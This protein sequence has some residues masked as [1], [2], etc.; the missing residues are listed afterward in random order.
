M[1]ARRPATIPL[2][3]RYPGRLDVQCRRDRRRQHKR[4]ICC[5][6]WRHRHI[7]YS[8]RRRHR[9]HAHHRHLQPR[10]RFPGSHQVHRRP[11]GG[12]QAE[13]KITVSCDG[14]CTPSTSWSRRERAARASRLITTS[15]PFDMH[16]RRDRRRLDQH[17]F[18]HDRGGQPVGPDRGR[19]AGQGRHRPTRTI[20]SPGP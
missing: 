3:R 11:G 17:C 18:G 5:H 15:Q 16:R 8:A 14:T 12:S 1:P 19:P 20:S 10:R 7:G 4:S 9:L 6:E 2:L 13:V